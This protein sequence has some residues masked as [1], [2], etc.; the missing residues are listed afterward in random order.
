MNKTEI[1]LIGGWVLL[2]TLVASAIV[3]AAFGKMEV[4][5]SCATGAGII[6]WAAIMTD[7]V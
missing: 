2:L 3:F 4:A 7:N 1:N 6:V 5:A